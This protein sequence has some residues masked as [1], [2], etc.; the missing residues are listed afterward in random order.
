MNTKP[1]TGGFFLGTLFAGFVVDYVVDRPGMRL[2]A[3]RLEGVRLV[4]NAPWCL[5]LER[6]MPAE[7]NLPGRW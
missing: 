4:D 1:L 2:G 6:V 7:E 3:V 5:K